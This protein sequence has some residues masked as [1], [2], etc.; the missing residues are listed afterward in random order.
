MQ[1]ELLA[2]IV[3]EVGLVILGG[4]ILGALAYHFGSEGISYLMNL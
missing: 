3:I 2:R 4:I 1:W